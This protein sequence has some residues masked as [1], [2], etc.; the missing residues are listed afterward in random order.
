MKLEA[1]CFNSCREA[2]AKHLQYSSGVI[3]P[4][5]LD[6]SRDLYLILPLNNNNGT[7]YG[8]IA[9]AKNLAAAELEPFALRRIE[10][11]R[12]TV[13]DR[14]DAY[15]KEASETGPSADVLP[16]KF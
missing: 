1:G 7:H 15:A 13:I 8:S 9:I 3:G 14:L 4:E 2:G 6:W 10:Q 11:L 12:R 5:T 16:E